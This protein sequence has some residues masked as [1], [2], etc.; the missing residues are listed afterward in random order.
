M[1]GSLQ[2]KTVN[3]NEFFK[4]IQ[5]HRTEEIKNGL[6]GDYIQCDL[7]QSRSFS[8]PK[9]LTQQFLLCFPFSRCTFSLLKL[10]MNQSKDVEGRCRKDSEVGEM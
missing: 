10:L 7:T 6:G 1:N 9:Y 3:E 5:C 2:R 8:W 4:M